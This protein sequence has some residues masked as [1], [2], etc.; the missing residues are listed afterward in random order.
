MNDN[1]TFLINYEI[2]TGT[3]N[4]PSGS[5]VIEAENEPMARMKAISILRKEYAGSNPQILSV[6]IE[7]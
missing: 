2:L 5:I 6:V 7:E 3:K 4:M 1:K